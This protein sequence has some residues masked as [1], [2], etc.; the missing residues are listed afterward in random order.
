MREFGEDVSQTGNS[1]FF[2]N[3]RQYL[4]EEFWFMVQFH[5]KN[6]FSVLHDNLAV[7]VR[8]SV[9]LST[10]VYS[11]IFMCVCFLY[12]DVECSFFLYIVIHSDMFLL[13][14]QENSFTFVSL[15]LQ[16]WFIPLLIS[17]VFILPTEF[18]LH[19]YNEKQPINF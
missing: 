7:L 19:K 11:Y 10:L 12:I 17:M 18:P 16:F 5:Q 13:F 6:T 4:S 15:C 9:S 1:N 3:M 8:S 14:V 2:K